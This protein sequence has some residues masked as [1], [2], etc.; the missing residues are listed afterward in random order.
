MTIIAV[1]FQNSGAMPVLFGDKNM[2]VVIDML[3]SLKDAPDLP[4]E[5]AA[6]EWLATL[7]YPSG[8]FL[9]EAEAEAYI[10]REKNVAAFVTAD[11]LAEIRSKLKMTRQHFGSE[12]G[13][14]GNSN[15]RHKF[16]YELETGKKPI[17]K[18][19]SRSVRV[20]ASRHALAEG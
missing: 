6:R 15:T 3:S 19:I 12:L 17:T 13:Y 1:A 8:L 5:T 4:D 20:L 7:P 11:D 2:D 18:K 9:S 14:G 10:T 16:I